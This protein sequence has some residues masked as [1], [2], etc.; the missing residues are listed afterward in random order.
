[1]IKALR[2]SK[3]LLLILLGFISALPFT[4]EE[5]FLVSWIS[6]APFFYMILKDS[7]NGMSFRKI[8]LESFLF[9]FAYHLGIYYFF[10]SLIPMSFIGLGYVGSILLMAAAWL[11]LSA[12]HTLPIALITAFFATRHIK[13]PIKSIAV[14]FSIVLVQFLQSIGVY[15]FTWSR[16]SLPQ[17]SFLPLIQSSAILG[18]YFVDVILV[19][20][21]AFIACAFFT[22]KRSVY[23]SLAM[24]LFSLNFL[25]GVIWMGRDI[26]ENEHKQVAVVQGN[27]LMDEKW[28]SRSSYSVYMEET[29]GLELKDGLVVWTET[30]VTADLN[31]NERISS[32]LKEYTLKSGNDM[33]VGG[34]YRSNIGREYNGAYYIEDGELYDNVYLKRRIVPF[35]EFLPFRKVLEAIPFLDSINLY[36]S[37]LYAGNSTSVFQTDDGSVG[38]LICFDSIFHSLARESV[39]DGAELL[40]VV[41]NDSWYKDDPAVYQHMSQ[42][43]WRSVENGRYLIRAAN[44]GVSCIITPRGEVKVYLPPLVRDT[45][46]GTVAFVSDKTPYTLL[47]DVIIIP[48]VLFLLLSLYTEIKASAKLR[49]LFSHLFKRSKI[50]SDRSES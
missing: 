23:L 28:G 7:E 10:F 8:F 3:W 9:F 4:F 1:M 25:F 29:L 12:F 41:T 32:A 49:K 16:L 35:G 19:T 30:A 11:V 34:F 39:S 31:T 18:P 40:V 47:G 17:C 13:F 6:F 46:E 21:N 2:R 45:A 50:S 5:L 44:S 38:C 37:D 36:S 22:Q 20:V 48:L 33:L 14:S 26:N 43:V 42:S 24:C 15:G 27:V